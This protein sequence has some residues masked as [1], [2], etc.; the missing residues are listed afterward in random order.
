MSDP[1]TRPG[2]GLRA[3]EPIAPGRHVVS[4]LGGGERHEAY[5][6]F[7]DDM[8][9]LVVAKVLRPDRAADPRMLAALALEGRML[10]RVRHPAVLRTF[11][12]VLG[13]GRPHLLLEYI[14]GPRLSTLVRRYGLALEQALSL[15]LQLAAGVHHMSR[16]GI[17]H[18]DLKPRN[19]IMAGPARIIDMSVAHTLEDAAR[20]RSR[21]GTA[22]YMAPEQCDPEGLGPVGPAADVWGLGVCLY[23]ALAGRPAFGRED[24]AVEPA[25]QLRLDAP[26]LPR[27]ARVPEPVVEVVGACMARAA[28]DRPT[29]QEVARTLEGFVD[30][31]PRPRLGMFRPAPARIA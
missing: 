5:L 3:G 13:G 24:A 7:D 10:D 16:R 9:H 18:L 14:E 2:W 21:V 25:P 30:H 23:E 15:G 31:L 19:I 12:T 8:H 1:V 6:A 11:G 20:I 26:A 28:V 22:R 29:A 17:V 27:R 4:L